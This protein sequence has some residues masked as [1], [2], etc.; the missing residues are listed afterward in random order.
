MPT[1]STPWSGTAAGGPQDSRP[2]FG[3]IQCERKTDWLEVDAMV[4]D[5]DTE[6]L[7]SLFF[8]DHF[9]TLGLIST[10]KSYVKLKDAQLR[11]LEY[12]RKQGMTN[13]GQ[14]EAS[15]ANFS[16]VDRIYEQ[17][18]DR[19]E[20]PVDE[21]VARPRNLRQTFEEDIHPQPDSI[22]ATLRPYQ[23]TGYNWLRKLHEMGCTGCL[24][25][26]NGSG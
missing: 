24:A 7:R 10:G 25:D 13:E 15:A 3:A 8:D 12:L 17:V 18:V 6:E 5:P 9:Q 19:E 11:Q 20:S 1:P 26:D 21:V 22:N 14:L 23:L 4:E 2:R 16:L